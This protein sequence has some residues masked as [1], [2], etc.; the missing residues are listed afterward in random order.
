MRKAATI[1]EARSRRAV[2]PALCLLA[3]CVLC[4]LFAVPVTA[5][6]ADGSDLQTVKIGYFES[7]NF[8]E[9][10]SDGAA[11]DGYGYEYLQRVAGYAGWRYEYVYGDW[12][13]LYQE[14]CDGKIDM[15]PG[16]SQT[17]VHA[18]QVLFPERSMLNETFYVYV[19][20]ADGPV[21][22]GDPLELAGRTI[23]IVG[24]TNSVDAYRSWLESAGIQTETVTYRTFDDMHAALKKGLIDAFVSSDN[25]A[26]DTDDVVPVDIVGSEP[27]YLA[28]APGRDDL[29]QK[30]DGTLGIM[31]RQ[32]RLFLDEL[33]NRYAADSAVNVYLAPD[34][35][36][37]VSSHK[38]LTIGYLDNYLPYCAKGDDGEPTG[39]MVDVVAELLHGLPGDWAPQ[40]R[41]RAYQ[42]QGDLVAAL[43]SGKVDVAFPVGGDAWYA[44][45]NGYN[46]SS[47]VVSP[48]MDLVLKNGSDFDVATK[49][50]AV[51]RNNLMQ[52]A[53]VSA[54][55]S[56]AT[57]VKCDSVEECLGA[58][59]SGKAGST[60]INGLRAGALLKS[61]T[62]FY[63]VQLP[64]E[65]LRCFAVA[66]GDTVLLRLINRGLGMIG[67]DYGTNAASRYTAGL[68]RYTVSDLVKD[69]LPAVVGVVG[70]AIAG[71]LAAIVRHAHKLRLEA[72]REAEQNQLLE[73][74]LARA[75]RASR[76]KDVML[77]NLSHDIRTPL[78]GILGAMYVSRTCDDPDFAQENTRRAR[79]AARQLLS[80]VDDLL[81]M[82]KLKSGDV[83]VTQEAFR[84]SKVFDNVL[85]EL[86][87]QA[88]ETGVELRYQCH[89]VGFDD[90]W[91]F[92]SPVYVRQALVNVL[93]N[94][95]RYNRR[96]GHVT[97]ETGLTYDGRDHVIL[98][99]SVE[100]DGIGMAPEYLEHLFE[101]F[102][103]EHSGARSV[104]PG[105]GLGLP[106]VKALLE[107]M[108]GTIDISSE[109]GRGTTAVLTIPFALAEGPE[110]VNVQPVGAGELEG[111]RIL[112]AEDNELNLEIEKYVLEHAGAQEVLC[113]ADGAE[114]V[115]VFEESAEGS[116]DAVL[117]DIMMPVMDGIAATRAIRALP[118]QDALEVPII[119]LT[120]KV[121]ADDR[122]EVL[123]AGM[124]DH[125]AKPIDSELLVSTL[126][127][128]R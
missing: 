123:D 52:C 70:L 16:V 10:A 44:E 109:L 14:L 4:C 12:S 11:K 117:M 19:A 48:T 74:A 30:L 63:Q 97:W 43:K 103:Q 79:N 86:A 54:H 85:E 69:N 81:E 59:R 110:P 22:R 55:L 90:A 89:S 93:D 71:V 99:C 53:Y 72:Q 64:E 83:E 47:A 20:T 31:E 38:T 8:T 36:Q 76:A 21:S 62:D 58:V 25:V 77:T 84:I 101:P 23:G 111:M 118:R 37:W 112:L 95:I 127:R 114:A 115:R 61:E 60:V 33:Q 98:T 68:Y 113:A 75:E 107:L 57:L 51:N 128:Y 32:D 45:R 7:R 126:S 100:D 34:E 67:E 3:L 13:E 29:L 40:I 121:F 102:Q 116:I 88:E 120:A 106:I 2:V 94:A 87:P 104:Y 9:G 1:R 39:L 24:G 18:S 27:Y 17:E 46:C 108:G 92:G 82:S 65:D 66:E 78:N 105:S 56:A 125:L 41:Y 6:A 124:N 35:S 5:R 15:L 122:R 42:S 119:A 73:D 96:G 26:Y 50:V 49:K 80:L 91:V 28:V